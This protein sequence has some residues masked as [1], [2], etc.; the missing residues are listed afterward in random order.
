MTVIEGLAGTDAGMADDAGQGGSGGEMHP[1]PGLPGLGHPRSL[2]AS[3][4]VNVGS[5]IETDMA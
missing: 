4:I 1:V 5:A 2:S 3:P